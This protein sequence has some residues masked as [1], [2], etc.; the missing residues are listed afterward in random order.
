MAAALA[1]Y[2]DTFREA[3]RLEYEF[4]ALSETLQS[5]GE[6]VLHD[7]DGVVAAAIDSGDGDAL[8]AATSTR[9]HLLLALLHSNTVIG[10]QDDGVA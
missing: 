9:E 7:I 8:V 4:R 2:T 3:E 6:R 1:T 10:H 5:E